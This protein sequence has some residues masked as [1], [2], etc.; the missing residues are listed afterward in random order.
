MLTLVKSSKLLFIAFNPNKRQFDILTNVVLKKEL[1]I[2]KMA[3]EGYTNLIKAKDLIMSKFHLCHSKKG[4]K[5]I[6][7]IK[8]KSI[9]L[10]FYNWI[11]IGDLQ[12]FSNLKDSIFEYW[13]LAAF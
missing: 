5:I 12:N 8:Q 4:F 1:K 11:K 7:K 13:I 9:S 10:I 6:L 2:K 3:K